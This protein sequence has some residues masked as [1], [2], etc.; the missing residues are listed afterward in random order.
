MLRRGNEVK[1]RGQEKAPWLG[2]GAD[3]G[4]LTKLDI[5]V[6]EKPWKNRHFLILGYKAG[7]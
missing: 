5:L 1:R 2:K 4:F 6:A 7:F 3:G